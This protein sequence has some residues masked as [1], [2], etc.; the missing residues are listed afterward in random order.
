MGLRHLGLL[1]GYLWRLR[2]VGSRMAPSFCGFSISVGDGP[3]TDREKTDRL[4]VWW[5]GRDEGSI[6]N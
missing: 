6:E 5:W 1:M 2:E 4:C 3:L